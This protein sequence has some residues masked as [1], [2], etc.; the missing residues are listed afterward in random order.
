MSAIIFPLTRYRFEFVA[1]TN[2]GL[3]EYAGSTLRGAFGHA[4]RSLACMTRAKTCNACML[5][6]S[7]PY[8]S[9]FEP[10]KPSTGSISVATPPVPYVIEP[11]TW[12]A[13]HYAPGD[14]LSFHF[15]LI[16]KATDQLPLCIMAW[17]RAFLRGVGAGDGIAELQQVIHETTEAETVIY[18]TGETIKEH[19]RFIVLPEQKAPESVTLQFVTPL[20]LQE[21]GHALPPNRLTP[22]PLLTAL[23]RRASLLA[24]HHQG[25]TLYTP[26][27]FSELASAANQITGEIE[28]KWRDW[29][30]RSSRQQRAMQ[31][32]GCIGHWTLIGNLSPFWQV[33]RLGE[34]THVGK[35]AS[36]GLG[37]YRIQSASSMN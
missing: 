18:Y 1:K 5:A 25:L 26:E 20:R 17:R 14:K 4:L 9:L 22:R 29:T 31:L 13:H 28:M 19:P 27:Q 24:E 11:P 35:E 10:Q 8:I 34:M 23:L 15:T 3:P 21:N 12:G 7:C 2:I 36:F 33:L 6:S 32:G 37:Q 16:G 30:R